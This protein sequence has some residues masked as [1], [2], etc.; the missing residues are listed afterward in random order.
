M[1]PG[2]EVV[3]MIILVWKE[4]V[5]DVMS[6]VSNTVK[7]CVI[8]ILHELYCRRSVYWIQSCPDSTAYDGF[9]AMSIIRRIVKPHQALAAY[10][11][12]ATTTLTG[13][14]LASRNAWSFIPR[15]GRCFSK[16]FYK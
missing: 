13:R 9:Y 8:G 14:R 3:I 10:R 1:T 11:S 5:Q 16:I 12:L 6:T 2:T 15:H 4:F 7:Q